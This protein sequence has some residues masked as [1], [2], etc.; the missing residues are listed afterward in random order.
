MT[1]TLI[2]HWTITWGLTAGNAAK[3]VCVATCSCT[4]DDVVVVVA[5]MVIMM[6]M[7]AHQ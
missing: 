5:M 1:A 7:A 4:E 2:T 6:E 3:G